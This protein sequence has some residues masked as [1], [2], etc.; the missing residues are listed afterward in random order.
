MDE[1]LSFLSFADN[2]TKD[3]FFSLFSEKKLAAGEVL[4][5]YN[6]S[7][8]SLFFLTGG[9]LAVHKYTGFQDKMQVVALLD[10]GAVVGE[11]GILPG[12]TRN[13]KVIA[14][15]DSRLSCLDKKD[16]FTFLT[17]FPIDAS[18][19]LEHLF[20]IVSLRLEKTSERLARIL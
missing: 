3:K 2:N 15:V 14:I 9:H 17:E 16:F 19:F 7:A 18:K 5:G 4:F 6:E 13:T 1:I 20:S 11:A 8:E 12:H 10:P